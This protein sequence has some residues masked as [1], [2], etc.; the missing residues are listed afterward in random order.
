M[1]VASELTPLIAFKL[2]VYSFGSLVH[3]FLMV[4]IIGQ[5][6]L[7]RLEWFLLTLM[8]ALF[9]W[10]SGNLLALNIGLFYGVGP[11]FLSAF[12][13][14]IPFSGFLIAS[15]IMVEVHVEYLRQ[16]RPL[17][18][19]V[20]IL[21]AVFFIPLVVAPWLVGRL[22]GRLELD[23]LYALL[24]FVRP[25]AAWLV[26]ALVV[27]MVLNLVARRLQEGRLRTFHTGLAMLQGC[28]AL[29][30]AEQYIFAPPSVS[31]LGGYLATSLMLVSIA[32]SVLVGYSIF[33]YNFLDLQVRRN[34]VYSLAGIFALL[35][36]LN[37]VRRLSTYLEPT[38]PSAVTEGFMFFLL[39]VLLE[40]I[41]KQINRLLH[42]AFVSE[43][44]QVQKLSTEIQE[45][46][47]RT[48]D[49]HS[50]RAFVEQRV[51]SEL[52]LERVRLAVGQDSDYER[53]PSLPR[54]VRVFPIHRGEDRLGSLV[55]T[56]VT[57]D[58]SGD[59]YGAL[60]VLADQLAA[61]LELCQLIADKV[62]LE[63]ALAEKAK[64]AFLGEMAT[65]IAHNVKNPLSSMKTLVQLMSEDVNLPART[66]EECQMVV[67]EIDRLN[68]NILQIL[69]Y[70]KPARDTGR[71]VDLAGVACRVVN[72]TRAEAERRQVRLELEPLAGPY[73]VRGGEEAASD[74]VS[75]LV[76][77]AL[78]VSPAGSTVRVRMSREETG[79]SVR[80][81]V[82]DQ[83]PGVPHDLREKI[84][85][86]FFTTRPGGTGLGLA[87]V[88]RRVEEI[89]G[90]IDFISP[91]K[92]EQGGG[93]RF[94]VRFCMAG[95]VRS[96]GSQVS[97]DG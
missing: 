54:K 4:L 26:A 40:P 19:A 67:S 56:P 12:S 90:E 7:R 10:N 21:A 17:S 44:E 60:Q 45:H 28:L 34:L 78:Q 94:L 52:G 24:P 77:N 29:G 41:K 35:I 64:M 59:L 22:L 76:G 61:A 87:I 74:I 13:R 25:L 6:R 55:V 85:Q 18:W 88:M 97:G 62:Q 68:D 83:G 73:E 5:R 91:L 47:K 69:R 37:F 48:G 89:G 50:L 39:V 46:A 51:A 49:I 65:R 43:F 36:Y 32:P 58:L 53:D 1:D 63:R 71:A 70:A 95:R 9:L 30:F 14:L 66:R 11:N 16:F 42:A 84:F 81:S 75:N 82:E 72:L 8:I 80:L 20:R 27:S 2:I 23:P 31:G 96:S 33:R 79:R 38:I 86:P 15:S 3:L 92:G 93:T 57:G